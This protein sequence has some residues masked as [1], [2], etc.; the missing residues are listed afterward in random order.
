MNRDELSNYLNTLLASV[1]NEDPLEYFSDM[2]NSVNV[3]CIEATVAKA[4]E[5]LKSFNKKNGKPVNIYLSIGG[6]NFNKHFMQG[7]IAALTWIHGY[8]SDAGEIFKIDQKDID[9]C[10]KVLNN[11][12]I[13][14]PHDAIEHIVDGKTIK[15][16]SSSCR[17]Y[18]SFL[19][20]ILQWCNTGVSAFNYTG[21]TKTNMEMVRYLTATALNSFPSIPFS[22]YYIG[23]IKTD[24]MMKLSEDLSSKFDFRK[25]ISDECYAIN[26]PRFVVQTANAPLVG[27][28]EHPLSKLI[29]GQMK[30]GKAEWFGVFMDSDEFNRI[31]T[32]S[33]IST[34]DVK[35]YMLLTSQEKH[36]KNINDKN[37]VAVFIENNKLFKNGYELYHKNENI[38]V[39][40][41]HAEDM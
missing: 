4:K 17:H 30:D 19:T 34:K 35:N 27:I 31:C 32:E 25:F 20:A 26:T 2:Y 1:S 8:V 11:I 5:E 3:E 10:K 40:E 18:A 13:P 6:D 22:S 14:K 38:V 15:E 9:T 28:A 41:N 7:I 21:V 39:E 23:T 37:P 29:M 12:H 36:N 33:G 16:H 24:D